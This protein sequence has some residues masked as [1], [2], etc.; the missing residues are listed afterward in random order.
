[1][2]HHG[3]TTSDTTST[4]SG[5]APAPTDAALVDIGI[6]ISSMFDEK[7]GRP[8]RKGNTSLREDG[9]GIK[10]IPPRR[11]RARTRGPKAIA[12]N[13]STS[14]RRASPSPPYGRRLRT[15]GQTLCG[16]EHWRFASR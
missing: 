4:S 8:G 3:Q 2:K 13:P 9:E 16:G 1:M 15:R 10:L 12:A 6:A 14:A 7:I 5:V 11:L